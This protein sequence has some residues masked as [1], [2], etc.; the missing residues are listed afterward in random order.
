MGAFHLTAEDIRIEEDHI[1]V[2]R[3]DCGNG[4]YQES[5][6]DLDQYIGNAD[7][8]LISSHHASIFSP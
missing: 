5:S 7:G 3:L 8:M 4:E 6:I 1:L 2:A